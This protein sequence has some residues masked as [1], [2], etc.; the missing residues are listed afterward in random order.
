M[1]RITLI[2][3]MLSGCATGYHPESYTGGYSSEQISK[4]T[5]IVT[6][7]G[8]GYTAA[9][10]VRSYTIKRAKELCY[11]EGYDGGFE[12]VSMSSD[13]KSSRLPDNIQCNHNGYNT[14]CINYGGGT[15][16]KAS[17]EMV[18]KCLEPNPEYH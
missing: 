16:S 7:R 6:F 15:V 11:E 18:I 10:T 4:D 13:T 9:S 8:N 17:S 5:Y 14:T 12:L 3:L 2:L 1:I